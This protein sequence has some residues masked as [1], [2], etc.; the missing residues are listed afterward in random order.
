MTKDIIVLSISLFVLIAMVGGLLTFVYA[1][2]NKPNVRQFTMDQFRVIVGL[3]TAGL[4]SVLVVAIFQVSAG[5]INIK[6]FGLEFSGAGGPV[7]MWIFAFLSI[8]TMIGTLWD[9]KRPP[10]GQQAQ[11]TE[12]STPPDPR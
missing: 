4:F 6:M 9:T 7:V 8:A 1:G 5:N 3:P 12:R 11:S 10:P 2:W